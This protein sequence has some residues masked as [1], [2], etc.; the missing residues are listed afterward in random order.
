MPVERSWFI[1]SL[2]LKSRSKQVERTLELRLEKA[3]RVTFKGDQ[4]TDL[5]LVDP[6]KGRQWELCGFSTSRPEAIRQ[7]RSIVSPVGHG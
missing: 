7:D 5:I 1:Y 6:P 4:F 3:R 2:K